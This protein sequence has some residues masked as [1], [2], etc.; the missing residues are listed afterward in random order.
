[1]T[2]LEVWH[3]VIQASGR[4]TLHGDKLIV[5][6]PEPLPD[7]LMELVR[8][9]KPALLAL[10]RQELPAQSSDNLAQPMHAFL[11]A[12]V[13]DVRHIAHGQRFPRAPS[14]QPCAPVWRCRNCGALVPIYTMRWGYCAAPTC[15]L[16]RQEAEHACWPWLRQA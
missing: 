8:Q 12:T 14:A 11:L 2:A 10:S 15:D 1:M 6:A 9:H 7:N 13:S 16:V 4:L 5:E 3:A